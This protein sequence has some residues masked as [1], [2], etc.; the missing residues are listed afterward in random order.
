MTAQEQELAFDMIAAEIESTLFSKAQDYANQ[1]RLSNFKLGGEIIGS[2]AQ[3]QCLALISTKVARLGNLLS[4]GKIPNN[5]S[6]ADNAKDLTC[7]G[8]LLQMILREEEF[9]EEAART[10]KPPEPIRLPI[11]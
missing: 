5:E 1:D 9:A 10:T 4:S 3:M 2:N 6:I 11:K 8:I 7:Y